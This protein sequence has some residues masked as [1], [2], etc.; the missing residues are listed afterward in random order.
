MQDPMQIAIQHH[1]AGRLQEAGRIYQSVLA[2]NPNDP[3]A[4]HLLGL[5][6]HQLGHHQPAT[7][8]MSRAIGMKPSPAYYANLAE[9]WR[10]L[11][12]LDKAI[13]CC[14][15]ALALSPAY[16]EAAN[17]LGLAL[18]QQGKL[19]EAIDQFR[20]ALM[21]RPNFALVHT[22]LA[23]AF[24]AQGE[25]ES[26]IK[27][28]RKAIECDPNLASAHANLGQLLCQRQELPEALEHSQK[29][30]ELR[31]GFAAAHYNLGTVLSM[32]GNLDEARRHYVEALRLNPSLAEA[33]CNLG[34][35]LNMMGK[36][37]EARQHCVE[38][39]RLNP[40]LAEAHSNLGNV[41]R[42]MN[43]FGEARQHL[44]KALRLNPSI[45]ET[46]NNLG[47]VLQEMGNL[48]EARQHFVEA[49][50]LNPSF[51]A[52]HS[53]LGSVLFKMNNFGEA[54]QHLVKALRLN[55]AFAAAHS[56]LGLLLQEMGNLDEA[57][58][59]CVEALRLNPSLAEAHS[60][61]GS[62]LGAMGNPDEAR[63]HFAEALRL[64]PSFA[65]THCNL[66]SLRVTL[67]DLK[68]AEESFRT[69]L[70]YDPNGVRAW[71]KLATLLC[72]KLPDDDLEAMRRLVANP[73][74]PKDRRA[75]LHFGLAQVFDAREQYTEA[76]E[77]LL[78]ANALTRE[79]WRERGENYD[80]VKHSGFV[81]EM[82][83]TCTPAYFHRLRGLGLDSKLPI[84]IIGLPRSGTTLIEQILASHS[85]VF[86]GDELPFT[87]DDYKSLPEV[88]RSVEFE[89][90]IRGNLAMAYLSRLD[91]EAIHT[92]AQRH[93]DRLR[94]LNPTAQRI[95]DKLP[96]NYMFL[97]LLAV[98]FPKAKF[99]HCRRDLRDVAVS[100]W[101][102]NFRWARWTNDP[103]HIA[104]RFHEYR[105]LM[106]H[107]R[108]TLPVPLLHIDY[109]E[110]VA[111]LEG[112]ARKLVSW[113][114]LEWEPACLEFH[115]TQRPI[116]T[117]SVT[118][119]RQPIYRR[120]LGRWKN[121]EPELG[122]LFTKLVGE[123]AVRM[124]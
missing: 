76:A 64:N 23:N 85:Q 102:T 58:Q 123:K 46:H 116:H 122:N 73:A 7:Q 88:M 98:L 27:H 119:V 14:R 75:S 71:E 8:F 5:V 124:E 42:K 86:G 94:A 28:Y 87:P 31:P 19:A 65:A 62:V 32:M 39:L 117:A 68:G 91:S 33:H 54:R 47:G 103:E 92:V 12:Q 72:S 115:R 25:L 63:Q 3:D 100:C 30:I 37:D 110:T 104:S 109:E 13:E 112:V 26:A 52:A 79:V 78:H 29:T 4:L 41:L 2:H 56:N 107:W 77:H 113:C 44:V 95:T 99:I 51:T 66:G 49:L 61:L 16:P 55:P 89:K 80:P 69:S 17:N 121:Y 43:N 67:N 35:V 101:M 15:A 105:R 9:V 93:L 18:M 48:D 84:F 11:G 57:R 50:R 82:I 81:N 114:G 34:I 96:E 108:T 24:R 74:L 118:Q 22:N 59:H 36:L 120:S 6:A 70:R 83:A 60:N 111:D 45:P 40:S 21:V 1:Q 10:A 20:A 106:E 97:G 90:P 53:N 38:A